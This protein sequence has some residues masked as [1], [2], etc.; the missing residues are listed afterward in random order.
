MPSRLKEEK[1]LYGSD[2]RYTLSAESLNANA[3]S[4]LSPRLDATMLAYLNVAVVGTNFRSND[5]V[6]D[7]ISFYVAVELKAPPAGLRWKPAS[8]RIEKL[9]TAFVALDARLKQKHGKSKSTV[10]K[11][12][13]AQLPDRTLFKDHAPSKVDQRKVSMISKE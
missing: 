7:D 9:Y 3:S 11:I 2:R 4:S 10:K 12:A 13:N 6:K 1:K 5:R 8:W